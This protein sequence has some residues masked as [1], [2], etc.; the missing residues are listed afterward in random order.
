M[1]V[2]NIYKNMKLQ[3]REKDR[4][5]VSLKKSHLAPGEMEKVMIPNKILQNISENEIIIE[6]VG[7]DE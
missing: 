7:G 6:L 5:I 2:N 4:V 1:R 3:I